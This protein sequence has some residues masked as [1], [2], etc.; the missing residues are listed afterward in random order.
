M[1]QGNKD[2][3]GQVRNELREAVQ[4]KLIRFKPLS[5]NSY[6][7]LRVEVYGILQGKTNSAV[8]NEKTPA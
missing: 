1:F 2:R 7:A 8:V 5:Y 6:P 3:N 4:A